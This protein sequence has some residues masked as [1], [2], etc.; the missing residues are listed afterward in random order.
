[1]GDELL[2]ELTDSTAVVTLNRPH[3][4]NALNDS[5][6]RDLRTALTGLEQDPSVAVVV[7]TGADPAFCAG[8]DLKELA[9]APGSLGGG[10][11]TD[12][13]LRFPI[14]PMTKP[15]IGA[16][17]GAAITG[18]FELAL[19]C[20]FLVASEEAR[21]ADTHAR[22]GIMPGWGL[23]VQ[24]ADAV[25][26]RRA[27]ELSAT[28][29]F[30]DADTALEW[31]LVNHVVAHPALMAFVRDLAADI[32]GNDRDGVAHV[33]G[34]YAEQAAGRLGEASRTEIR[35][36]AEW[37][38]SRDTTDLDRKRRAVTERGRDQL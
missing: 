4:R 22:V 26:L 7:L 20:D 6:R 31:G 15:V 33:L 9:R 2:V 29:N 3:A 36:S 30:I 5:L 19:G 1:M 24:L 11:D 28:G 18:G 16:I 8:L 13:E 14:P 34:T 23:T 37:L 17:N 38:S 32:A 27:R 21:F 35:R 10:F 12:A 25:G